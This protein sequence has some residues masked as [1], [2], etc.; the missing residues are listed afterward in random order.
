[1]NISDEEIKSK[2]REILLECNYEKEI[3]RVA[4]LYPD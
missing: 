4:N 2:W 1:M 3:L